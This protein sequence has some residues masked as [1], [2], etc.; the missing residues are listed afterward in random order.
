MLTTV[1]SLLLI[2]LVFKLK[3][4]SVRFASHCKLRNEVNKL[5]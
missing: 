5:N 3:T 2:I 1:L 4:F